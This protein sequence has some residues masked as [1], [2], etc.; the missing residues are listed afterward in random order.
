MLGPSQEANR[1]SLAPMFKAFQQERRFPYNTTDVPSVV[2]DY[3]SRQ[4]ERS[5]QPVR[6]LHWRGRFNSTYRSLIQE[7]LSFRNL[8]E[9]DV[10]A[11]VAWLC[12]HVLPR[13]ERSLKTRFVSWP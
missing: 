12:E 13:E 10:T 7:F 8:V 5:R 1:L 2:V 11:F 9:T 6:H 4:I 3:V